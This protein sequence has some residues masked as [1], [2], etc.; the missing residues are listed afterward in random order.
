MEPPASPSRRDLLLAAGTTALLTG[1]ARP[2][3]KP[4]RV[5]RIGVVSASIGGKPQNR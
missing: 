1:I 4:H 3:D 2:A 5:Y